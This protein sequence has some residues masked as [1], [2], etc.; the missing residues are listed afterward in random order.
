MIDTL[1]KYT[2]EHNL[3]NKTVIVAFSGGYDSM[4]LLDIMNKISGV[5]KIRLV[6]AHFNHNWRGDESIKEQSH[7]EDFCRNNGI[8]FYTETAP[9]NTPKTE[10]SAR[11]LRYAFFNRAA[12][13]YNTDVIFTAH[14]FDD[15]AET[16]LYRIIKGTGIVGLQ[17]IMPVRDIYYR[18]LLSFRRSEIEQYCNEHGLSPNKDSSNE[19]TKYNRNYI[20]LEIMPLLEK[21]NP[22]IKKSLN[23]LAYIAQS[24]LNI[25]NEYLSLISEKLYDGNKILISEYEKL[26]E[27]IKKKIIYNLLYS[28]NIEYDSSK[29]NNVYNFIEQQI[30]MKK[31]SKYS[32]ADN[33]WLYFGNEYIELITLSEIIDDEIEITDCGTYKFNNAVFTIEKSSKRE[34]VKDENTAYVNLSKYDK[35]LLRTRRDGDIICPLGLSGKMKLKKYLINK[36]VPQHVRNKLVL[37][38]SNNEVLWVAGVGVSDKI[39]TITEPTHKITITYGEKL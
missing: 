37:L 27:S 5:K 38:T 9:E 17:G 31:S 33:I 39:K 6:A 24:E 19:N 18:P 35:L 22:E 4:C 15:N 2:D 34:M 30:Y 28:C 3:S 36:K 7:C 10:T 14:N 32:L 25:G 13:K 16:I 1:L 23:N 21:I 29:I 8:E 12:K 20:R 11:D 26:S